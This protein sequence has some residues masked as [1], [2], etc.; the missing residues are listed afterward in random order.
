MRDVRGNKKGLYKYINNRRNTKEN[1]GLPLN[2]A[3]DLMTNDMEKAKIL[4]AFFVSVFTGKTSIQESQAPETRGKVWSKEVLSSVKKDQVKEPLN[5]LNICK[6]MG[7]N[8]L[9]P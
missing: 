2:G 7:P 3:G 6:S 4:N 5:K 9:H 8:G 1:V